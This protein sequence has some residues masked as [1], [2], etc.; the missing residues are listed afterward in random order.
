MIKTFQELNP[1]ERTRLFEF[2]RRLAPGRFPDE[3]M[4]EK[5]YGGVVY[6]RGKSQF[7]SWENGAVTGSVALVTKEIDARGEA[8]LHQVLIEQQQAF[9]SLLERAIAVC[10]ETISLKLGLPPEREELAA[11][12]RGHGFSDAY[13]LLEMA[14]SHHDWEP[15]ETLSL[16]PL[17]RENRN[18]FQTILNAAF[19]HSPNGGQLTDEEIE[20]L[21]GESSPR[22]I[23]LWNGEAVGVYERSVKEDESWID[24]LGIHPEYQKK[25]LGKALL[26]AVLAECL[27]ATKLTVMSSNQAAVGLY[28]SHGFGRECVLSVWLEKRL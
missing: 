1:L 20:G 18:V 7:S 23:A 9:A 4:M 6:D 28:R 27:P 3:A 17:K 12:A 2:V 21:L 15:V 22:G 25:G 26:K 10:P 5:A 24:T 19:L 8:F 14:Y 11:I 13:S 16:E